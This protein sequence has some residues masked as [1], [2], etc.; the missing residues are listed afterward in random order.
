[1]RISAFV[2]SEKFTWAIRSNGLNI[3]T[4]KKST[5]TFKIIFKS[6]CHLSFTCLWHLNNTRDSSVDDQ[7]RNNMCPTGLY[8]KHR[9]TVT[10]WMLHNWSIIACRHTVTARTLHNRP[11]RACR[12]TVTAWTLHNLP[13]I[14]CRHTVT[15]WTLHNRPIITCHN[16]VTA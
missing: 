7:S 12:H 14:T 6:L 5:P 9:H 16:T 13:I 8:F 15:A 10:A 1:M 3:I 2:S 11:I 4:K